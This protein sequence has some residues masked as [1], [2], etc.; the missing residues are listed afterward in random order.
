M[1]DMDEA[2]RR[3][4]AGTVAPHPR[5]ATALRDMLVRD[6]ERLAPRHLAKAE[7]TF[8]VLSALL[9]KRIS[10][11]ELRDA[12]E[13]VER[14]IAQGRPAIEVT[15]KIGA[16]VFWSVVRA[17]GYLVGCLLKDSGIADLVKGLRL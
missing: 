7:R 13:D 16:T 4:R 6:G 17:V 9:P 10:D 2:S 14:R 12:L 1:L 8:G 11:E 15:I 3:A 5:S